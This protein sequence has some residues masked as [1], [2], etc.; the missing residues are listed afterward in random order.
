MCVPVPAARAILCRPLTPPYT[1]PSSAL[2]HAPV[3]PP[4]P[5]A[6]AA[7]G[8]GSGA[9]TRPF[10]HPLKQERPW[11]PQ[12]SHPTPP[13]RMVTQATPGLY[14][15]SYPAG[16]WAGLPSLPLVVHTHAYR[17]AGASLKLRP[18]PPPR[19][20]AGASPALRGSRARHSH[21]MSA[22]TEL[23]PAATLR[24]SPLLLPLHRRVSVRQ[25]RCREHRTNLRAK[26]NGLLP[27]SRAE[28]IC[29]T[30]VSFFSEQH[31][32]TKQIG[33]WTVR[34]GAG[35]GSW[36]GGR[37]DER[38]KPSDSEKHREPEGDHGR[39]V[40]FKL[41]PLCWISDQ[42]I[43]CSD[44]LSG[45]L[46]SYS[47]LPLLELRNRICH[48][49]FCLTRKSGPWMERNDLGWTLSDYGRDEEQ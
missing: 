21:K 39:K 17:G 23:L 31:L 4:P 22:L 27:I 29:A 44:P 8:S 26:G 36:A 20:A 19:A 25:R 32:L 16:Q 18:R 12:P 41:L 10:P 11:P 45:V 28:F 40:L 37:V 9:R 38:R 15:P 2:P 33:D 43:Q 47:L 3:Q 7:R 34:A 1:P 48:Q 35:G 6:C 5:R 30:P 46:V 14:F 24:P 42:V 13:N 49:H